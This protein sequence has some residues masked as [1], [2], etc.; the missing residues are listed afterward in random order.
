MPAIEPDFG[1]RTANGARLDEYLDAVSIVAPEAG[2][3]AFDLVLAVLAARLGNP[4]RL[5]DWRKALRRFHPQG[6]PS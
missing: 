5:P 6:A 4:E 3:A 2:D 1:D